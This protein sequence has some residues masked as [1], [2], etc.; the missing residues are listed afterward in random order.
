LPPYWKVTQYPKFIFIAV[1]VKGGQ[2]THHSRPAGVPGTQFLGIV[3][4]IGHLKK[5]KL[6]QVAVTFLSDVSI[7]GQSLIA[8]NMVLAMWLEKPTHLLHCKGFNVK[9][10]FY[11]LVLCWTCLFWGSSHGPIALNGVKPY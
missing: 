6:G 7:H 10:L 2:T 1:F 5:S 3:F 8:Q 9:T 11:T 4:L